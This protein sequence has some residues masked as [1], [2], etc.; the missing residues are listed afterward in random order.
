MHV[1]VFIY[2]H[3]SV[4]TQI[5]PLHW[6]TP[7]MLAAVGTAGLHKAVVSNLPRS[8]LGV[9]EYHKSKLSP[10]LCISRKLMVTIVMKYS[11]III[12]IG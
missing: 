4:C 3:L 5:A 1:Y 2:V 7:N 11:E 10:S 8:P 12:H 6:F 9:N